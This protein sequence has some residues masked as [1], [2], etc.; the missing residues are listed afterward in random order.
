MAEV[1]RLV[2]YVLSGSWKSSVK[3]RMITDVEILLL[4]MKVRRG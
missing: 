4:Q 2:V 3:Q 1:V